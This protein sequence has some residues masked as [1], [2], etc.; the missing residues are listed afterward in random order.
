M[1]SGAGGGGGGPRGLQPAGGRGP[2]FKIDLVSYSDVA[3][4][5][6]L[7]CAPEPTCVPLVAPSSSASTLDR[8]LA[9]NAQLIAQ[10]EAVLGATD[11]TFM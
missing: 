8:Q 11:M 3:S 10:L 7:P 9:G 2:P 6:P 5:L 4:L 1:E